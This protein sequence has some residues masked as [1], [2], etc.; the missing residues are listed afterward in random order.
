M[1]VDDSHLKT[2]L[3]DAGLVSR[4]DF[5][6]AE[7]EASETGESV[8]EA[9]V[10]KNAIGEDELRRTYAYILGI[11]FISIDGI[12]I[13]YETLAFIPEP[14]ARRNNIVAY[15]HKGSELEI[16]MLDTEDLAMLDFLKKKTRLK[17]LP[18]LTDVASI[19]HALKQYQQGLKNNLGEV[20]RCEVE[21][22]QRSRGNGSPKEVAE[23]AS[24]V[25]IVDILLKHASSQQA[26]D[27]HIEPIEDILLVRYRIDGLLHDA[28]EFPKAAAEAV[29]ARIKLLSNMRLEDRRPQEGR[30][31]V[32]G[33]GERISFRVST[34][35]TQYGERIVM[36]LMRETNSGLTLESIGFRGEALERVHEALR[37]TSGLILVSGRK[38]AGT[39]TTLYTLLDIL[40][41]PQVNASTIEEKIEYPLKR[42]N[43]TEVRPEIGFS[44]A[45]GLRALV[46]Q[47][48]DIIM[49]GEMR[50]K[51]TVSL[52]LNAA[53]HG[54]LV[55]STIEA[56]SAAE[57]IARLLDMGVDPLLLSSTLR[58]S[59]GQRLVR[60]LAS[61]LEKQELS[62]EEQSDLEE[63][64]DV[65]AVLKA[66]KEENSVP[67]D[68]T[69]KNIPFYKPTSY[70]GRKGIFE[71]L[72]ITATIKALI[73]RAATQG[74]IEAEAR[75]AGMLTM[76]EDG[77]GKAAQGITTIEEV[78][79]AAV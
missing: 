76:A 78:L 5:D 1:R 33:S 24:A 63:I 61:P 23:D 13:P 46:H 41:T 18:R 50:D 32:E 60:T 35:P 43:Q 22:L 52:A 67:K 62:R 74:E 65:G 25:R 71:V 40:N 14:V 8:G 15:S 30:F 70:A 31:G 51:E 75:G 49:L 54:R 37:A 57:A 56:N 38:G 27:V 16:A 59:I 73:M 66:L 9:L 77:I 7:R 4:K 28:M 11:P 20:I 42:V 29:K 6:A 44:A 39:S 10:S 53:L 2:F 26:S 45:A 68:A 48:A 55:L 12:H 69:W 47:D 3:A 36:R 58:V 72:P 21:L 34:L 64:V 19:K 79:D 17:I